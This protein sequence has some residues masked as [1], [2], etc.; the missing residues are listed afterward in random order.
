MN[1]NDDHESTSSDV[2]FSQN[3]ADHWEK[4]DTSPNKK[5]TPTKVFS[6][7]EIKDVFDDARR[8]QSCRRVQ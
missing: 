1:A 7:I 5:S 3:I 2:D 6:F 8:C 4:E